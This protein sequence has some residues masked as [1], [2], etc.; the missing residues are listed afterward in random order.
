ML[1]DWLYW[2]HLL[3]SSGGRVHFEAQELCN[4]RFHDQT[5]RSLASKAVEA[6][7][8]GEYSHAIATCLR[9]IPNRPFLYWLRLVSRGYW[10]W[11]FYEYQDRFRPSR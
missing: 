9:S 6:K 5:T 4:F 11:I 1:G 8:M 3:L 2:V 10:D 7:R